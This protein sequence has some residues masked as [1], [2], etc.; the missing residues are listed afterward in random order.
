M[1]SFFKG[2]NGNITSSSSSDSNL[3]SNSYFNNTSFNPTN[4]SNPSSSHSLSDTSPS[5]SS[6][7]LTHSNSNSNN[8]I[9]IQFKRAEELLKAAVYS[10]SCNQLDDALFLYQES[11]NIWLDILSKTNDEIKKMQIADL[12]STYMSKAELVK[13]KLANPI[14]SPSISTPTPQLTRTTSNNTGNNNYKMNQGN[15]TPVNTQKNNNTNPRT[16]QQPNPTQETKVDEHEVAILSEMLDSSPGIR[17]NINTLYSISF[18]S[19]SFSFPSL[20]FN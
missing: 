18:H 19:I 1:F 12:I 7:S 5:P 17:L 2:E 10:D 9:D 4:T 13:Q 14:S 11:L 6:P 8:L 15:R 16:Q 3:N 20:N